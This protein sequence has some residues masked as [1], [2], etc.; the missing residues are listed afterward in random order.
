M[1]DIQI[2][3]AEQIL[4]ETIVDAN[5]SPSA[6]I[7]LDKIASYTQIV[8]SDGSVTMA[9]ALNLGSNQVNNVA[10]G[11]AGSDAVNLGQVE[12]LLGG[13]GWSFQ[14]AWAGGTAYTVN[15]LVTFNN[16]VYICIDGNTG[17][18]PD[19]SPTYWT[20]IVE[21]VPGTRGSLIYVASGAPGTIS[22]QQNGDCYIN[23]ANAYFYQL[24]SGTWTYQFTLTGTYTPATPFQDTYNNSG[25]YLS[26]H[27]FTL[28]HT[29]ASSAP[30]LVFVDN[31]RLPKSAYSVS[32]TTL[33]IG[34][35]GAWTGLDGGSYTIS[36]FKG[37]IVDYGY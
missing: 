16:A 37:V 4:S 5:I 33:T 6:A 7:A 2:N 23:S 27:S 10:N 3:G 8:L 9:A 21:G 19:T 14:G 28:T 35:A 30:L 15:Q 26:A 32:G 34:T 24:V 17:E 31:A 22:G 25:S 1:A 20:E 12:T 36:E 18:E 13:V 29:P 11:T